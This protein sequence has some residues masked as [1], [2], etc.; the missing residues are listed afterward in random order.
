MGKQRWITLDFFGKIRSSMWVLKNVRAIVNLKKKNTLH[1]QTRK[2]L[3]GNWESHSSTEAKI[4]KK[5]GEGRRE[6]EKEGGEGKGGA[7]AATKKPSK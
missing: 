4:K 7:T 3:K 2:Y 1:L 6:G 5:R